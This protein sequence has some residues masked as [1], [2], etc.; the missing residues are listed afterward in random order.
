[1]VREQLNQTTILGRH[2]LDKCNNMDTKSRI[3]ALLQLR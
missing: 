3:R 1:M 2:M